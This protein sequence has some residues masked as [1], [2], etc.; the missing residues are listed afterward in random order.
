MLGIYITVI[1]KTDFCNFRVILIS[2]FGFII[3][4]R[5]RTATRI[6]HFQYSHVI[7]HRIILIQYQIT[8]VLHISINTDFKPIHDFKVSCQFYGI[9]W[10][11]T[12]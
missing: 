6:R 7:H 5:Y 2:V 9:T 10:I 8:V 1:P 4:I 11:Q 3:D 12:T